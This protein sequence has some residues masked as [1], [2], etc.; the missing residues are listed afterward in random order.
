MI[1]HWQRTTVTGMGPDGEMASERVLHK[2]GDDV[3][4]MAMKRNPELAGCSR[5]AMDTEEAFT[6]IREEDARRSAADIPR[7]DRQGE[8][9]DW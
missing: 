1:E 3:L 6:Q 2:R 7:D 8:E 9:L 5:F 4:G